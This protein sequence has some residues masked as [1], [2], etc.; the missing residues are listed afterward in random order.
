MTAIFSGGG[1]E[2]SLRSWPLTDGLTSNSV[3]ALWLTFDPRRFLVSDWS[4][5]FRAF[6]VEPL[7]KLISNFVATMHYGTSRVSLTFSHLS[8][9]DDVIKL[10][11]FLC[12][13]PF[14]RG[15]HRSLVNSPHK[16]QWRGALM[17]SLICA[18]T[19]DWVNNRYPGDL[20][21][22]RAHWD[23]TVMGNG[24]LFY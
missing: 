15:I 22:H 17:F 10:K 13:W 19:N 9:H 11:H 6:A 24:A 18:W 1:D 5:R 3:F 21:R 4:S 2:L 14:V 16:G 8:L 12:Y 23:V 20:R 7:I